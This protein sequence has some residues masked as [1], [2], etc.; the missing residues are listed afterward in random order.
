MKKKIVQTVVLLLLLVVFP[1][2]SWLFLRDGLQYRLDAKDRLVVKS[3]LPVDSK[4]CKPG[5]IQ[6]LYTPGKLDR[7]K[8]I[9]D[10]FADRKEILMFNSLD[11]VSI[12][13]V[14][15]DSLEH[16]WSK[17][18]LVDQYQDAIFLI[19]TTCA[20]RMAYDAKV[21]EQMASLVEDI[22]FLLPIEKEKDFLVKREREK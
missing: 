8:P 16:A 17:S 19:D 14:T 20:I 2:L 22:A 3:H 6:V 10:H 12:N 9:S 15:Q 5:P 21:D 1:I 18:S 7:I 13:N 4:L 11:S